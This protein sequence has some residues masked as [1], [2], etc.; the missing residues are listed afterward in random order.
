MSDTV[1]D[2]LYQ[3]FCLWTNLCLFN[4]PIA[5]VNPKNTHVLSGKNNYQT[6]TVVQLP[7][8]HTDQYSEN[9][10]E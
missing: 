2:I 5:P 1:D 8:V 7:T 3:D 6:R 10:G 4:C 9:K